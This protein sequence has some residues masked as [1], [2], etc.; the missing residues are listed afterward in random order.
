LVFLPDDSDKMDKF[1]HGD[2]EL[3]ERLSEPRFIALKLLS[4]SHLI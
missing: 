2:K 3:E 4:E 1:T